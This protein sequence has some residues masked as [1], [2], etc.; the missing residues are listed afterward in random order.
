[1]EKFHLGQFLYKYKIKLL[2]AFFLVVIP[3][4]IVVSIYLGRSR[5]TTTIHFNAEQTSETKTLRDREFSTNLELDAMKLEIE[6]IE[7]REPDLNDENEY[8]N[9][10][11]S[12]RITYTPNQGYQI[13]ALKITAVLQTKWLLARGYLAETRF[14]SQSTTLR[15]PFN[16]SLPQRELLFFKVTDPTLYLKV[17]YTQSSILGDNDSTPYYLKLN[18]KNE[19]PEVV[20][21][22]N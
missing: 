11:Y 2:L 7:L 14:T 6:W 19:N 18:L 22:G 21:S 12:F 9:G 16:Y 13:N 5:A 20:I 1:V 4:F 15:V 10:S 17:I 8:Y 3:V